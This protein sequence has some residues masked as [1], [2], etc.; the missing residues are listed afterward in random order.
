MPASSH[1]FVQD[2]ANENVVGALTTFKYIF[3]TSL[4]YEEVRLALK[5]A[6]TVMA[7]YARAR[8]YMECSHYNEFGTRSEVRCTQANAVDCSKPGG[9]Q[10]EWV[11]HVRNVAALEGTCTQKA[12]KHPCTRLW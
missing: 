7:N 3:G 2:K 6:N 4:K 11:L 10:L 9:Q 5:T 8:A 12:D 1:Q